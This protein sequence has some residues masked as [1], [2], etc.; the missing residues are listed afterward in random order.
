MPRPRTKTDEEII[1]G[2]IAAINRVGPDKL[3]LADVAREVGLAPA[4]LIQRF[5]TKRKLL[6][7]LAE[8][9]ANGAAEDFRMMRQKYG[10]P[11]ATLRGMADCYSAMWPTPQAVAYGIA[12]L[13]KDMTDPDFQHLSQKKARVT[14]AAMRVLFEDA[15][16][17]G[18]LIRCDTKHLSRAFHAMC[19]GLMLNWALTREGKLKAWLEEGIEVM[20]RPYVSKRGPAKRKPRGK[21]ARRRFYS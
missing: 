3:T 21:K 5:G 2:T 14:D 20:L 10:S 8:M 12:F 1:L 16:R 18:E 4:T 9:G 13:Y 17:A 11:L 6:L 7:A 19:G 15:M